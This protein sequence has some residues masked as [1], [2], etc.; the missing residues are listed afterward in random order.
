MRVASVSRCGYFAIG[1]YEAGRRSKLDLNSDVSS[2]LGWSLRNPS[3]PDRPI[4]LSML[5]R[6]PAPSASNDDT[7]AI[8]LGTS[9]Q[10]VMQDPLNWDPQHRPGDYF[11][12]INMNYPIVGSIVERVTG[13]RF[14]V[15]MRREV[16]EPMKLEAC[17][18]WSTCNDDAVARAVESTAPTASR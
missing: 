13:E 18:N 3:F 12:Y 8:P 10:A 11:S 17:F 6:T 2:W 4:T 5:L 15:W 16:L 9:L 14:D 7:Y 1:V